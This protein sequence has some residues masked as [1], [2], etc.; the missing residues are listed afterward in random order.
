[1]RK[2]LVLLSLMLI[3]LTGCKE[4]ENLDMSE[5]TRNVQVLRSSGLFKIT[6]EA[7]DICGYSKHLYKHYHR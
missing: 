3:I 2:V 7:G 4:K 5:K 1:M 6:P